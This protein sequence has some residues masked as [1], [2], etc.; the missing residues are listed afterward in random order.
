VADNDDAVDL[1]ATTGVRGTAFALAAPPGGE[2][3]EALGTGSGRVASA[4]ERD[5]QLR[6]C[7][8]AR[9][10]RCREGGEGGSSARQRLAFC[11]AGEERQVAP[12]LRKRRDFDLRFRSGGGLFFLRERTVMALDLTPGQNSGRARFRPKP[13]KVR[14]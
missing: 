2:S 11:Y 14:S 6:G 8:L 1:T 5:G 13:E 9:L 4:A 12:R 7:R 10:T 3:F